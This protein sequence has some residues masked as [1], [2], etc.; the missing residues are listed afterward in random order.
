MV[1]GPGVRM[2]RR[3]VAAGGHAHVV[4]PLRHQIAPVIDEARAAIKPGRRVAVLDLEEQSP[5]AEPPRLV[6]EQREHAPADAA[7]AHLRH[8]KQLVDAALAAARLDA[9]AQRQDDI[10][11]RPAGQHHEPAPAERLALDQRRQRRQLP[12]GVEVVAILDVVG[13]HHRLE[14]GRSAS[15]TGESSGLRTWSSFGMI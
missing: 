14:R 7:A 11:D 10:A 2:I 4:Q 15:P 6:L 1:T 5:H 3:A 8:Q 13:A 9:E 12:R